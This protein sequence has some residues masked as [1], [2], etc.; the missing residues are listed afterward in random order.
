MKKKK[1]VL[2]IFSSFNMAQTADEVDEKVEELQR[3]ILA[4]TKEEFLKEMKAQLDKDDKLIQAWLPS[5]FTS[6]LKEVSN[7]ILHIFSL[8]PELLGAEIVGQATTA[9]PIVGA[10]ISGMTSYYALTKLLEANRLLAKS[11]IKILSNSTA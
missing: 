5:L 8:F 11:T 9:V 2:L 1:F 6:S 3:A 10:G 4:A 7:C